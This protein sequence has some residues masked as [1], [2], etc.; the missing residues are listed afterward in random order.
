MIHDFRCQFRIVIC[1]LDLQALSFRN[2]FHLEPIAE[3]AYY[4]VPLLGRVITSLEL[5]IVN[6]S[7]R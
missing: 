5:E 2:D 6:D 3:G 7:K 4:A 1:L